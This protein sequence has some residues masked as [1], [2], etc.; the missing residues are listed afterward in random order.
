MKCNVGKVD[1]TA[2]FI[3][4]ILLLVVG[5]AVPL[6]AV[7][8]RV[9]LALGAIAL[10]TGAIRYCPVNALLGLNTCKKQQVSAS[11]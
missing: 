10:V 6:S 4:G 1:M 8:Q 3:I 9:V 7:W 2:R 11:K 5:F